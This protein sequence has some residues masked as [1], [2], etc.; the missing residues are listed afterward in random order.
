MAS[1]Q[2]QLIDEKL[3]ELGIVLPQVPIHAANYEL[4]RVVNK[5]VYVGAHLP[6]ESGVVA[7]KGLVGDKV[8]TEQGI[9][10][11][12][13]CLINILGQLEATLEGGLEA[14]TEL[15]SLDGYVAAAPGFASLNQVM[16]GASDLA[17]SVFGRA[18]QHVRSV[19]GV[20]ALPENAS[21]MIGGLFR[22]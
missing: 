19:A 8:E 17:R 9:R 10:A 4:V 22:L 18:G 16:D 21:V 2:R 1:D 13:L 11:A 20:T 3:K 5:N 15:V 6:I 7:V 12:R 14:I